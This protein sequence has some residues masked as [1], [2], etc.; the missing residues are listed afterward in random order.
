MAIVYRGEEAE[1]GRPVAVKLL[2]DNLAADAEL[3]ERFLREASIA[4]RLDHQNVVEVLDTGETGGR[5]YIVMEPSTARR[6]RPTSR[7]S[8]RWASSARSTSRSS[9]ALRSR[10]RTSSRSS[11]E[12]SAGERPAHPRRQ[13]QARGL[14]HRPRA[15]RRN[16]AHDRRKRARNRRLPAPEQ[17]RGDVIGRRRTSGLSVSIAEM[18]TGLAPTPARRRSLPSSHRLRADCARSS[19]AA[20]STILHSVRPPTRSP[21]S[22]SEVTSRPSR[23]RPFSR[24]RPNPTPLPTRR[25]P[26]PSD[27][28]RC[29]VRAGRQLSRWCCSSRSWHSSRSRPTALPAAPRRRR[30]AREAVAGVQAHELARGSAPR[31]TAE[32][33]SGVTRNVRRRFGWANRGPGLRREQLFAQRRGAVDQAAD[34]RGGKRVLEVQVLRDARLEDAHGDEG[35]RVEAEADDRERARDLGALVASAYSAV[36]RTCVIAMSRS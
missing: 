24:S 26:R 20:S 36:V 29:G 7:G 8:G 32:R 2:A 15:R 34:D 1:S 19:S 22:C 17:A 31:L 35:R 33:L 30:P 11:T 12:T 23:A 3:R 4:T 27:A 28:H 9:S 21:P 16:R 5:P 25:R 10:T 18:T 6:S 13:G 14:R